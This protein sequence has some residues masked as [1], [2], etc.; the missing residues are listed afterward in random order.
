MH[1]SQQ[2]YYQHWTFL[3]HK[4]H[5]IFTNIKTKKKIEFEK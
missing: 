1:S 5:I 2:Y 3:R 4:T